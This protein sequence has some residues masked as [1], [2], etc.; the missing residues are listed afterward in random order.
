MLKFIMIRSNVIYARYIYGF[1]DKACTQE[2][3]ELNVCNFMN[4][5]VQAEKCEID[6]L[7]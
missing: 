5:H 1:L 2:I 6:V 3:H 4:D 7:C